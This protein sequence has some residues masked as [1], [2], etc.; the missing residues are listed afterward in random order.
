MKRETPLNRALTQMESRISEYLTNFVLEK[1]EAGLFADDSPQKRIE[2][3][4]VEITGERYATFTG[5]FWTAKQRQ[6]ASIHEVSYRACFKPQLPRFFLELL[7]QEQDVVYDPFSGRG[8]TV[9]E[10]GLLGRN[11]IANDINPLSRILTEARYHV[12]HADHLNKRLSEIPLDPHATTDIDLSMFYHARTLGELVSLRAYLL[13]KATSGTDDPLDKWIRMVATNRLTGHSKGF[14]SVYTLPPNQAVSQ[15]SQ[16]EINKKLNQQPEYRDVRAVILKKSLDLLRTVTPVQI[17]RLRAAA[18]HAVFLTTDATSTDRIASDSV[19]LT[20][21]S[22]P[23]LDIVDYH[24]DN[25]LRCWF[26]GID[27]QA[28]AKTITMS[29]TV[30]EW[31]AVMGRVFQELHRITKTGGWIAFEVGEVR[32][33]SIRLDECVVPLGIQA[34]FR[35]EGIVINSQSFTK[36]SNIWGVKNNTRGT[37]TNRI[38]L[39]CKDR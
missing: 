17:E 38:V 18:E 37:N 27:D 14:F 15:E 13:G 21:T 19:Q 25:W 26:N 1:G 9:V 35:C 11:I 4:S 36:T 32:N 33:G 7:T 29:K 22:P 3:G 12:P 10:A 24:K 34:G 8:T 39:F 20:V 2:V 6:A 5:E 31:S 16:V 23:F 30:N 28:V